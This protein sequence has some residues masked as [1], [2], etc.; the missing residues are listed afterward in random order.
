MTRLKIKIR[1]SKK[2]TPPT[3]ADNAS[4]INIEK[5][6]SSPCGHF[7]EDWPNNVTFRVWI[8]TIFELNRRIQEKNVLTKCHEDVS[9]N[10]SSGLENCPTP[11]GGHVFPLITTIFKL[12]RD[13]HLTNL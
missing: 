11:P 2:I 1:F 6:A 3:L 8:K 7:H 13:I 10:V 9:K 4:Y 5:I 12:V